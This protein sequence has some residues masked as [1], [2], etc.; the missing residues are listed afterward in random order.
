MNI[1]ELDSKYIAGTYSRFD[2]TFTHGQGSTLY[3]ENEK[4]S[5]MTSGKMTLSPSS[6]NFNTF[7]IS[8]TH[9]RR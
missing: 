9:S 1:K 7:Q 8:I 4:E 6:K 2:V 3:D 5:Q